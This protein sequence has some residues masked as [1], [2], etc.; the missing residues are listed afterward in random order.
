[1]STFSKCHY[2]QIFVPIDAIFGNTRLGS[3]LQI[4]DKKFFGKKKMSSYEI[5]SR[6][7]FEFRGRSD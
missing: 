2:F 7:V 6:N 4:D 3:S 5:R 1:M